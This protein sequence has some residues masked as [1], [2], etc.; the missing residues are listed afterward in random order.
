MIREMPKTFSRKTR[1]NLRS[2][3]KGPMIE[4]YADMIILKDLMRDGSKGVRD[5]ML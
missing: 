3:R 1:P 5:L 4:K 2:N